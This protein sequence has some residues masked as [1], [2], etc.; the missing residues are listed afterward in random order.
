[1]KKIFVNRSWLEARI[2]EIQQELKQKTISQE[3]Q[4]RLKYFTEKTK[5]LKEQT[6]HFIEISNE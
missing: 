1:M 2:A 5:Q 3:Q 4:N 6:H